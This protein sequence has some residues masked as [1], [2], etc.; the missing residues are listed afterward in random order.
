MELCVRC[1]LS[2]STCTVAN[3]C[4]S[5]PPDINKTVNITT[6]SSLCQCLYGYYENATAGMLLGYNSV[7]LPCDYACQTCSLLPNNCTL[8]NSTAN[9]HLSGT[10]C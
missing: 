5:C 10:Y 2:C 8:C 9:R 3:V 7:C 6:G 4:S 1:D